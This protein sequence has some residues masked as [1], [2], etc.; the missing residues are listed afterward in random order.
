LDFANKENITDLLFPLFRQDLRSIVKTNDTNTSAVAAAAAAAVAAGS[1][2]RRQSDPRHP[3]GLAI[4]SPSHGSSVSSVSASQNMPNSSAVM[5]GTSS[6][7]L[8]PHGQLSTRMSGRTHPLPSPPESTSSV[9][10]T[11]PN[12]TTA[13]A[14]DWNTPNP[15]ISGAANGATP[16]VPSTPA[17]APPGSAL[18][19]SV[20]ALQ[21]QTQAGYDTPRQSYVPSV[22]PAAYQSRYVVPGSTMDSK[23][24]T[25]GS[26]IRPVD[27]GSHTS[28]GVDDGLKHDLLD[29]SLPNGPVDTP[30]QSHDLASTSTSAYDNSGSI[31]Y[32]YRQSG[33]ASFHTEGQSHISSGLVGSSPTTAGRDRV[34]VRSNV[35]P[36]SVA[37]SHWTTPTYGTSTTVLSSIPLPNSLPQAS[38]PLYSSIRDNPRTVSAPDLYS[39][40]DAGQAATT[41]TLKRGRD[42]DDEGSDLSDSLKRR[43][44]V[45]HEVGSEL[46]GTSPYDKARPVASAGRAI[47][48]RH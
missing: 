34:E 10:V 35:A 20:Q 26:P 46:N 33:A 39:G 12:L 22:D 37:S 47:G 11:Q 19:N 6:V 16:G 45:R 25:L 44:T 2:S 43:K 21:Q 17:A 28:S 9:S 7:P 32:G 41:P 14:Y 42:S 29:S 30:H 23:K 48:R 40:N 8:T 27:A 3:S 15:S 24:L 1:A 5:S 38:G 18:S 13:V 31:S 4:P 36:Q